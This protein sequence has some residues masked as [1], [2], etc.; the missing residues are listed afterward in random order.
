MIKCF[1]LTSVLIAL[2]TFSGHA[3]DSCSVTR[4]GEEFALCADSELRDMNGRVEYLLAKLES[5]VKDPTSVED[6]HG[7]WLD[8]RT[9][10][11]GG[12]VST[13]KFRTGQKECFVRIVDCH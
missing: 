9:S 4:S 12:V 6:A 3:N 11:C 5:V 2:S 13:G 8:L 1:G 7:D 10:T